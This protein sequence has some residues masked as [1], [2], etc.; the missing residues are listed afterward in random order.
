[1]ILSKVS[2]LLPI[3]DSLFLVSLLTLSDVTSCTFYPC[4]MLRMQNVQ[5]ILVPLSVIRR[6]TCVSER[7]LM[8]NSLDLVIEALRDGTP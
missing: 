1:M 2:S 5:H 7:Q 3:I 8:S 4:N 6:H